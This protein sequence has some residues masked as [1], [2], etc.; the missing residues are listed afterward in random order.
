MDMLDKKLLREL[1]RLKGQILAIAMVIASG[2]AILIMALGTHTSLEESRRAYY[3]QNRF[4][5]VFASAKRAPRSLIPQI[6]KLP[7]V[8]H[9]EARLVY[10][11]ILDIE[12]LAE[13]ATAQLV[14]LPAY[15]EAK[16]NIPYLRAGRRP[17]HNR[18]DEVMINAA[19]A[20]ANGFSPG[21]SFA[22]IINGHKR[23]LTI[24]G[25]AVSPEF[26]YAIGPGVLVPDNKRFGILWM[27][28][29]ALEDD[30]DLEGAFNDISLRLSLSA[31]REAAIDGLDRILEPYGGIGAFGRT[32]QV[33]D[34]Y[35]EGELDQL[36]VTARIFP[37]VF[38]SV[39]AFLL[40]VLLS[41]LIR[42]ER[43]QIGLLKA[44]GYTN[45]A[46]A[47][48]Y[49]KF[50]LAITAIGAAVGV[51]AG[52]WLG[53]RVTWLY[54]DL[55]DFPTL[56]YHTNETGIAIGV[57]VGIAAAVIGVIQPVRSAVAL[58][59]A[60]AMAPEAPLT[61]NNSILDASGLLSRIGIATRMILRHIVRWPFRSSATALG[62]A[63]S[64]GLLISTLF[65]LDSID[66]MFETYFVYSQRQDM[67]LVFA[68]KRETGAIREVEHMPGVMA[69][70]PNRTVPA[71]LRFRHLKERTGI[72]GLPPD[73]KLYRVLDENASDFP[74]PEHGIVLSD[75]LAEDLAV[76]AGD[77][78][79]VEILEENRPKRLM[80]VSAITTEYIGAG[81]Y[82]NIDA[83]HRMMREGPTV[84]GLYLTID[85]RDL[86][87]LYDEV[88]ETPSIAGV[89]LQSVAYQ[90]A[91]DTIAENLYIIIFFYIGFAS[92]IA[93]GVAYNN[94][95]IALSERARALATLRVLGFTRFEAS[96]ILLGEL[97]V[98]TVTALPVGCLFGYMLA[99]FMAANMATELVQ[100]PLVITPFTYGISMLVIL[101]AVA[102]SALIVR[103]RVDALDLISVLK[104]RE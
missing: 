30:L 90:A 99:A 48:H 75:K 97:A 12:G 93:I 58:A 56:A 34:A 18:H 77:T 21:D 98:L 86:N 91:Q 5:D 103:R 94:A 55:F 46:V 31:N 66:H 8:L 1:W 67:T 40:N 64:L 61:Y 49:L 70:E 20:E 6:E 33:S 7:G 80:R 13:P 4:A 54:G 32:D 92:V 24:T 83:L 16:L 73:A 29:E 11:A 47:L 26:V 88:K 3:E 104:T 84:S 17:F 42:L 76:K 74:I 102:A 85:K 59:P 100:I 51:A 45:R 27:G 68:E 23:N 69:A 22:A 14:S 87:R 36:T 63:A 37:T 44:L 52:S 60:V 9:A 62:I 78:V 10:S 15:G 82:M 65:F 25:I 19:F 35:L 81:A 28:Q 2:V 71:R 96:S 39:S 53:H 89:T 43:E 79:G 57:L 41:R 101:L 95:R 38:L 72:I 50:A